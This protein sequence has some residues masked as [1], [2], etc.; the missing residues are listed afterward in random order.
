MREK[1]ASVSENNDSSEVCP[2]SSKIVIIVG[3]DG[4]GRMIRAFYSVFLEDY[5][6]Q[7]V[8]LRSKGTSE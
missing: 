7:R 2:R 3:L 5:S 4:D 1:R 8:P 6:R